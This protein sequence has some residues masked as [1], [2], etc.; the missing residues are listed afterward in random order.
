MTTF[1]P[2]LFGPICS[3]ANAPVKA[4]LI[5]ALIKR[6]YTRVFNGALR[7]LRTDNWR[8]NQV[9][10]KKT[11]GIYLDFRCALQSS[12]GPRNIGVQ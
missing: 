4:T 12:G 3:L 9:F 2:G 7:R 5:F 11:I 8:R 6:D 1:R 10:V